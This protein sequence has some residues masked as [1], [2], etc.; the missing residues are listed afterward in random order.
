M[1]HSIHD[2]QKHS[3]GLGHQQH[4]RLLKIKDSFYP[5]TITS[6]RGGADATAKTSAVN[7]LFSVR[8][9]VEES[10]QGFDHQEKD[11]D[12]VSDDEHL[13]SRSLN[14]RIM[15]SITTSIVIRDRVNGSS[16]NPVN[17]S[18]HVFTDK[19]LYKQVHVPAQTQDGKNQEQDP[20]IPCTYI[21]ETNLPTDIGMFR[22]RAYRVNN[23]IDFL[24]LEKNKFFGTEPCVIYSSD[25]SPFGMNA[26]TSLEDAIPVRIHDQC[27][28]SEVF[29]SKRYG[30]RR[31]GLTSCVLQYWKNTL[32]HIFFADVTVVIN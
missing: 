18:I 23:D 2:R 10:G 9:T 19:K 8:D 24:K 22:L 16:V 11:E 6:L 5:W 32:L 28:T 30:M 14:G 7:P 12:M 4:H 25:K 29:R 21:A 3:F 15:D 27:V 31:H 17:E 20:I 26:Q 13:S 1:R